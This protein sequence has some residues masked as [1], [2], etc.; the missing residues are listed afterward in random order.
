[1][2]AV[3]QAALRVGSVILPGR[4]Q[5]LLVPRLCGDLKRELGDT[6]TDGFLEA[7]LRGM[8][9]AFT[10][11]RSYRRN[12]E[13]FAAV[14]VF[15]TRD[16]SVGATAEFKG[17]KLKV[18]SSPRSTYDTRISFRDAGGLRKSLLAG[19]QDLLA[20]ML[21]DPV[22]AEGNLS[23]LY[24]FGFLAKELTLRLGVG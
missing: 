13:G 23:Y 16:N 19:D 9:V 17:G 14:F 22:D 5:D 12:I 21:S 1:M 24:R 6:V 4:I 18:E 10:L 8:A 2:G 3:S 11:S 7:L 20:T 15:R